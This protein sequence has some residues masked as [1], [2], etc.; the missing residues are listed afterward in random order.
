MNKDKKVPMEDD[1]EPD[2]TVGCTVPTW[3]VKWNGDCE[4]CVNN[5][6]HRYVKASPLPDHRRHVERPGSGGR[7]RPV[8]RGEGKHRDQ[9]GYHLR[10]Q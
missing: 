7:L 2:E 4:Q 9:N 8:A 10:S 5:A 1:E 3:S 6:R